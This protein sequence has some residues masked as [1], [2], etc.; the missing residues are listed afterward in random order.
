MPPASPKP[1]ARHIRQMLAG[2]PAAVHTPPPAHD[3]PQLA[4]AAS[5]AAAA[6]AAAALSDLVVEDVGEITFG[7][8]EA[9]VPARVASGSAPIG[10]HSASAAQD[11]QPNAAGGQ[12]GSELQPHDP[13]VSG[14]PSQQ[15]AQQMQQQD[16]D[17]GGGTE[18]ADEQRK[19][20]LG[21]QLYALVHELQPS[22]AGKITGMML[23]NELAMVAEIMLEEARPRYVL[24]NL[25]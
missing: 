22:L 17:Q 24:P 14:H 18:A 8:F 4:P 13:S 21:A 11:T 5:A 12:P 2:S 3:Q 10:V 19:Q 25:R 23:E 15:H 6:A 20:A 1:A 9:A 7:D 16:A